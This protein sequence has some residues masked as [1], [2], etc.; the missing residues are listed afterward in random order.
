M[1]EP[2]PEPTPQ[3]APEP[4]SLARGEISIISKSGI[5]YKANDYQVNPD[6]TLKSGTEP[7]EENSVSLAFVLFKDDGN[8][9]DKDAV[10]TITAG[11]STPIVLQGTGN[12]LAKLN[13]GKGAYYYPFTYEFRQTGQHIIKFESGNVTKNITFDVQ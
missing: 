11:T 8:T 3:P 4:V 1:P 7:T 12:F 6:G 9:V 5:T 10:V 2:T 13:S